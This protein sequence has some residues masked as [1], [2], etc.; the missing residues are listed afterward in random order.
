MKERN[1][2]VSRGAGS[3]SGGAGRGGGSPRSGRSTGSQSGKLKKDSP[4]PPKPGKSG[5]VIKP[6]EMPPPWAQR[7]LSGSLAAQRSLFQGIERKPYPVKST[8]TN[9][10]AGEWKVRVSTGEVTV[11]QG[12]AKVGKTVPPRKWGPSKPTTT[13]KATPK[14]KQKK[15][16]PN[17]VSDNVLRKFIEERTQGRSTRLSPSELRDAQRR[18]MIAQRKRRIVKKN[19]PPKRPPRWE[20]G[21]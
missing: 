7:P 14:P 15:P 10:P 17:N 16:D 11:T 13:A 4:A 8:R 5:W 1:S 18:Q 3:G 6:G 2:P 21:T 12:Q 19:K 20:G 9:K